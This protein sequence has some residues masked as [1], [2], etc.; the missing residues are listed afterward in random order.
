M[1]EPL[2]GRT[3][4]VAVGQHESIKEAAA[5]M[6]SRNVGCL[7]V[8]D[9][10]GRFAGLVS[11]RDIAYHI[12][13][14][15]KDAETIPV[16]AI[17]IH[18]V[19]SCPPG[20]PASVARE[21]MT[22]HRIRHLPIVDG[23]AVVGILSARDVMDQQLAE[24]REAAK[25]VAMLS[26]CLKSIDLNE[27]A[28]VVTIE[29]P[30]LFDAKNCVLCLY[31]NRSGGIQTP[32]LTAS[33]C[34]PCAEGQRNLC[35]EQAGV[36]EDIRVEEVVA[37]HCAN[38]GGW[39]PRIVIPLDIVGLKEAS[40]DE[41]KRLTGAL[42]MCGLARSSVADRDL[43]LYKAKLTRE[44]LTAHL[45]NATRY[46][47][48]RL[49]SL[50]D[51]LTGV[52]SRR[53]LEDKLAA[54][55]VRAR[56]YKRPFSVAII[57][58][59]H[60]KMINDTLGHATGDEAIRRLATCM[61]SQKR[62]PD[63]L[64]RYGGDE[65]VIVLPETTAADAKIL[66]ER[67]R[68]LVK[69]I[70]LGQES[71]LSISCGIAECDMERDDSREVMRRA[72]LAL[73]EA[74]NAGRD[75]VRLWDSTMGQRHGAGDLEVD[76]IKKLQRRIVG[77]SEKAEKMFM[78]SIWGLVQALEAKDVYAKT[79]SENV[80][81]YAVCV[82][83]TMELGAK[84]IELIQRAAMIHDIGKIGVP[85]AILFKPDDLTA[86]E[87]VVIE[88]HP[89]IAV[90]ILEKMSFLERELAIVRHHHE[91][92]NGQGYPDHLTRTAIPL[93]ARILAV[94]DTFDALTATRAY[95]ASR[96]VSEALGMLKDSAGYEF[97]PEVIAAM[98]GWVEALSRRL[99]KPLE[100]L[101]PSDLLEGSK[102]NQSTTGG[103]VLQ[104]VTAQTT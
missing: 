102:R 79:H 67:I 32:E 53:L 7:I 93:G 104:E 5:K 50:T 95:H 58:L 28:E 42:C 48:A 10:E 74:K 71:P 29:A 40:G 65:F 8:N 37:P 17:M 103:A 45:T 63:V 68:L 11:E 75:C 9:D 92:W 89:L 14:A 100:E 19:I 27:A 15:S 70:H 2:G 55:C 69:E 30:K 59:D 80:M 31:A 84:H 23:A 44:I 85:D 56:R 33:N 52:G 62:S 94:A 1:S 91:K 20:T 87:R 12:V 77:L 78:E 61:K 34:C 36:G 73:Y 76:R 4:I 72:D 97:D 82:A 13:A 49:T 64:A 41:P 101:F 21:I 3:E 35:A 57:D 99:A 60:F 18:D 90:R 39:P 51:P 66:L 38:S 96:T 25:E 6:R 22:A 83:E 26:K 86:H 46:Q 16:A 47:Q 24:D 81:R 54:E 88:Q 98:A 43:L